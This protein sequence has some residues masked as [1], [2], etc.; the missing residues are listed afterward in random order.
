[1]YTICLSNSFTKRF[2]VC[3]KITVHQTIRRSGSF[4]CG[5]YYTLVNW[6]RIVCFCFLLSSCPLHW[7][8]CIFQI[9]FYKYR[10]SVR[11][12]EQYLLLTCASFFYLHTLAQLVVK[13]Y[14]HCLNQ[15]IYI[16]IPHSTQLGCVYM[17]LPFP[18]QSCEEENIRKSLLFARLCGCTSVDRGF[19][20]MEAENKQTKK[21][22]LSAVRDSDN[23]KNSITKIIPSQLEKK[24]CLERN[25]KIDFLR[26]LVF[27]TLLSN[28]KKTISVT[29]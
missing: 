2:A 10:Y 15:T 8:V 12:T 4:E 28:K 13:R 19:S 7:L 23:D 5:V 29:M 11:Y 6:F 22:K 24:Y 18:F 27:K 1:M 21:L 14:H 20:Q 17:V 9:R 3:S 26:W 16:K 25:V